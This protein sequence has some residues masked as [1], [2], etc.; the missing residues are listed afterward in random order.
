MI[1]RVFFGLSLLFMGLTN[2]MDF[3]SFSI[4]VSDAMGPLGILG[5]VWSYVYPALLILG[6]ALFVIG[7][8]SSVAVWTVGIALGSVPAGMLLKPI[9]S[10]IALDDMLPIANTAFIWILVYLMAVKGFS[11]ENCS[12]DKPGMPMPAAKPM[13]PA[14][15]AK[16][17]PPVVAKPPSAPTPVKAMPPAAPSKVEVSKPA[18][19]KASAPKKVPPKK[20]PMPPTPPA[21]PMA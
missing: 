15:P 6:G 12:C 3:E 2:Y 7:R 14:A 10:G 13:V 1:I 20:K 8:F 21:A 4:I 19:A 5:T 11:H 18:V 9:L 17:M 16:T